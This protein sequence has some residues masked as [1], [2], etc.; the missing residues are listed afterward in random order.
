[1]HFLKSRPKSS[2]VHFLKV[3]PKLHVHFLIVDLPKRSRVHFL[4]W[5]VSPNQILGGIIMQYNYVC[6]LQQ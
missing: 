1:M 5:P 6:M 2:R 3:D 4:K